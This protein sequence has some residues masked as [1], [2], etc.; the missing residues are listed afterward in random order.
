[1]GP[2]QMEP[3]SRDTGSGGKT[4][5]IKFNRYNG[6]CKYGKECKFAHVCARCGGGEVQVGASQ[7]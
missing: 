5:C 6:D 4:V 7:P 1:M 3:H 2:G